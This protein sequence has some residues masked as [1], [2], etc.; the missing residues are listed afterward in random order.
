MFA[1]S[2]FKGIDMNDK[3][4]LISHALDLKERAA[5]LSVVTSTN[6]LSA[7]ELSDLLKYER[8]NNQFIDTFYFGGHKDAE[9][10]TAVF[11]PKFYEVDEEGLT[12]FFTANDCNPITA[13]KIKKDKFSSL[14]HRDYLGSLM[15]LGIKREMIGDIITDDDGCILFC[16]KSIADFICNN[17]RQAGRGQL[18]VA[19][20]DMNDFGLRE[21]KTEDIF[22]TVASLRL[23]CLVSAAF[24][25]SRSNAASLIN[26]GLVYV[27][28]E[29]IFKTDRILIKGDKL[30]VRGKGKTVI[31]EIPGTSKKG[32]IRINLKKYI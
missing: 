23:D 5:N 31:D 29:Q 21:S 26:Q 11:V 18:S 12:E 17:L 24:K 32:R 1:S 27:N 22:L 30:V 8:V 10:K 19:K 16:L 3:D 6:F 7:D 14:S 13:L 9:R 15:G 28:S 20:C 25:T 2:Y 4:V